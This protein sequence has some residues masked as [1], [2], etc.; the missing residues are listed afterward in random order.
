MIFI[1]QYSDEIEQAIF[2]LDFPQKPTNLYEPLRYFL[3]LGGKRIRPVLTLMAGELFGVNSKELKMAAL[4]VELFH[5]FTLIHDDIMDNAPL[6][7]NQTTV[8]E[9]WNSN[10]AILAGDVIF[11]KA[12]ETLG[13]CS[14]NHLNDLFSIF[15]KTASEVCEGQQMDMDFEKRNKV[16]I[17]EYIEMI[18]LKTSVLLGCALEMGAI[19]GNAS[20]VDRLNIYNFGT[21]LGIAF[22]IQDDILDL[23][24]NPEK[25]GKQVGG[26]VISNKKTLLSI[27]A[28]S[29][30]NEDD[31]KSL[32]KLESESN[33]IHKVNSVKVIY[34]NL[35]V[36]ALC[37]EQMKEHYN[38]AIHSLNLISADK[39]DKL[40]QL[41][42]YVIKRDY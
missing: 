5:N 25:V 16:E 11:V 19:I 12:Y 37:E 7:R 3:K 4:A 23:F 30:A 36:L 9:R 28:R 26:D 6:R 20:I 40:L 27:M 8:H 14:N 33:L 31:L 10:I 15:S 24:G 38:K 29:V 2:S 1:N 17:E 21:Q 35:G 41:A 32:N 34:E 39:K 42:E 22:Q 13:K 18:R